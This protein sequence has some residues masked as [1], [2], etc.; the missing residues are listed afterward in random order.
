MR[1]TSYSRTF[2]DEIV[3]LFVV[4]FI[5]IIYPLRPQPTT[6]DAKKVICVLW[7]LSLALVSPYIAVLQHK[8]KQC[9]ETF[10]DQGMNP[11]LYTLSIFILQY[12]LPITLI[13]LSYIR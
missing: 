1:L 9:N 5:A 3:Y 6:G 2:H 13:G 10:R 7:I 11:G 8:D 4:R 12:V